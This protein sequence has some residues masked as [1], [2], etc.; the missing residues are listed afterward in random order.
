MTANRIMLKLLNEVIRFDCSDCNR[1]WLLGEYMTHSDRGNCQADPFAENAIE[2]LQKIV[3][4][5]T[6]IR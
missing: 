6:I 2:K 5:G 1:H 4:R 3:K